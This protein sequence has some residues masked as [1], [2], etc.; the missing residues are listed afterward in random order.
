MSTES[1]RSLKRQ[2]HIVRFLLEGVYV[3]TK[4]IQDHLASIGMEAELRTIQ[5][6][7]VI[8]E[9]IFPLERNDSSTPHGWRWQ[10]VPG[11][12]VTGM[13]MSQ[14]LILCLAEEQLQDVLSPSTLT[15]LQPLFVKARMLAGTGKDLVLDAALG[16]GAVAGVA[17]TK[18]LKKAMPVIGMLV[19][20][21]GKGAEVFAKALRVKSAVDELLGALKEAGVADEFQ[22][23]SLL[24][25]CDS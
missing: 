9:R 7:L 15:E 8:L 2:W 22:D 14:A 5:R 20:G 3:S 17:A 12:S 13:N 6:D 1:A 25:N 24:F 16:G 18:G 4:N 19:G 10:R 23:I 21:F 11:A